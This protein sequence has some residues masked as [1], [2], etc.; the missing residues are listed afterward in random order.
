MACMNL[1]VLFLLL[2]LFLGQKSSEVRAQ[3][4]S[5]PDSGS[6]RIAPQSTSPN[7]W[8]VT[9]ATPNLSVLQSQ[10][11]NFSFKL[12]FT[13]QSISSC[14]AVVQHTASNVT[15]WVG[16]FNATTVFVDIANVSICTLTFGAS[17][18]LVLEKG[19]GTFNQRIWSTEGT[20][21]GNK[22]FDHLELN[23]YGDLYIENQTTQTKVWESFNFPTDTLINGQSLK[24]RSIPMSAS[25]LNYEYSNGDI[26][27]MRIHANDVTLFQDFKLNNTSY[28]M[29]YDSYDSNQTLVSIRM[30]KTLQVCGYPGCIPI[31]NG[32]SWDYARLEPNGSL[33]LRTFSSQL[34]QSLLTATSVSNC[35]LPAQC[36]AFG[37]C[38]A[39]EVCT[40]P[41]G[42]VQSNQT[43]EFTCER[44]AATT[45]SG[46]QFFNVTGQ[47]YLNLSYLNAS[48]NTDAQGCESRCSGNC[49]CMNALHVRR[50]ATSL[51]GACFL[52]LDSLQTIVSNGT[53]LQTL[54]LR[55]PPSPALVPAPAPGSTPALVP[56]T[57]SSRRTAASAFAGGAGALLLV[58]LGMS[59]WWLFHSRRKLFDEAERGKFDPA[60]MSPSPLPPQFSYKELEESTDNFNRRLGYGGITSFYAGHL[61]EKGNIAVKILDDNGHIKEKEFLAAVTTMG[62]LVHPNL[63]PLWGFCSEGRHRM[64]VYELVNEG[65]SLNYFLF[66]PDS[67]PLMDAQTRRS[68]ALE[69]ARGLAYLHEDL[70]IHGGVKPENIMIDREMHPQ[71]VD[72]GL[73][74]L[75]SRFQRLNSANS[76][77]SRAYMAPEWARSP[78]ITEKVDVYSFG[79]VMLEL[80]SGRSSL[81][82][83]SVPEE[84]RFLPTWG[85]S[86]LKRG[87]DHLLEVADPRLDVHALSETDQQVL[88][89]MLFVALWCVQEDPSLRPTMSQVVKML[90][91]DI[92]VDA[93]PLSPAL[94]ALARDLCAGHGDGETTDRFVHSPSVPENSEMQPR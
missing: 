70:V 48:E 15:I 32:G 4:N 9:S 49:S 18:G 58:L 14:A 78:P 59:V 89:G 22:S 77:G 76:R 24:I 17:D 45:C 71:L 19:N 82:L 81:I 20:M 2:W 3:S 44:Q 33:V 69:T 13:N 7:A 38:S 61:A 30:N 23:N 50:N 53:G 56:S 41:D 27:Y 63:V 35:S 52:N 1:Q 75:K 6:T 72:Y 79:V 65:R 62:G 12:L 94:D 87:P 43:T 51:Q 26:F 66:R 16:N 90:N 40:C 91:G 83:S 57:K 74:N 37:I 11:T 84:K 85:F 28:P 86:V 5:S 80:V 68:I 64:L 29:P 42:F 21:S 93:P 73:I 25:L 34:S 54:F 36:G 8:N 10:D 46:D 60:S 88:K 31:S 67:G 55:I 47:T 92:P 39:T